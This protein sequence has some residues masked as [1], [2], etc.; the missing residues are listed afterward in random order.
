VTAAGTRTQKLLNKFPGLA[1]SGRHN[2]AMITDR[3]KLTTKIALYGMSSFHFNARIKSKSFLWDVR[4]EQKK[5]ITQIFGN[6]R[7]PILRKPIGYAALLPSGP[8]WKKSRLNWK[9]KISNTAP[10]TNITQSQSRD[11]RHR[12]MQEVNSLCTDL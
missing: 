6:V 11:N 4:R 12:R 8:T 10:N 9:M 3:Q 7:R 2:S 1:T 5:V